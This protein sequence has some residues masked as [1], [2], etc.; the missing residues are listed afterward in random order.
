MESAEARKMCIDAKAD[1]I[2]DII[3]VNAAN[4]PG[5]KDNFPIYCKNKLSPETAELVHDDLRPIF[6][7]TQGV[8]L[9]QEQALQIFRYAGFPE[10]E[11][12]N[13]RRSI[14]KKKKDVMAKLEVS[15]RDGL[16]KKGWTEEQQTSIWN[17]ML[18]Q[19]EY[20]FNL[21]HQPKFCVSCYSD[22]V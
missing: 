2:E 6:Q 12:D 19:A 15:F 9:Y 4:R 17:L 14:G 10:E 20:S 11:V 3:V 22:V 13:A 5:T 7:R 8:L 21:G 16:T 1:N 18:K